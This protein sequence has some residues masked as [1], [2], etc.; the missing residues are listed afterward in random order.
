MLHLL[1]ST[2]ILFAEPYPTPFTPL[3][4]SLCLLLHRLSRSITP[5]QWENFSNQNILK[6]EKERNAS[7]TLRGVVRGV[8]DQ[9]LEDMLRQRAVVDQAFEQRIRETTEAKEKLEEHLAKVM[10]LCARTHTHTQ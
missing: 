2:C 1:F 5:S 8:L 4:W 7:S 3:L 6:A 9:T 10:Y